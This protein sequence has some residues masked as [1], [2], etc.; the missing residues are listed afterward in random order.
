MTRYN[1]FYKK[2]TID[3]GNYHSYS[4][5]KYLLKFPKDYFK[6][7]YEKKGQIIFTIVILSFILV[8]K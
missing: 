8:K 2:Y 5:I 1:I 7:F 3:L 6:K 4:I